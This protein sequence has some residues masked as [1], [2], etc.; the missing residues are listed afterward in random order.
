[1]PDTTQPPSPS[2][3]DAA[4]EPLEI[5][6][7]PTPAPGDTGERLEEQGR[8]ADPFGAGPGYVV[9]RTWGG[10]DQSAPLRRERTSPARPEPPAPRPR[11][12]RSGLWKGAGIALLAAVVGAASA[13]GIFLALDEDSPPVTVV[14]QIL[15]PEE[16][17][18]NAAAVA[19]RVLPSIVTVQ[20]R[21]SDVG[22]FVP[23]G[24][25]S[26]VVLSDDGLLITNNHVVEGSQQVRVI[27]AD[28]RAYDAEVVGTDALSDVAVLR[29]DADG[30]VPIELGASGSMAVGDTAIAI[31]SPLGLTGGPSVTVGVVSAFERRVQTS[32]DEE[33]F[34]MLQTDAPI[35][36]GSSGGALVDDHGRLIGITTA[37]GIS[38]VGAEG[39]G[40]AIPIEMV[41]RIADDLIE[42]GEARHAFLGVEGSTFYTEAPDGATIPGGVAVAS[43]FDDTAAKLSGIEEGDVILS[44]GDDPVTTMEQLV[45]VI[46]LYRVDETVDVVISRGGEETTIP[47]TLLERPEGV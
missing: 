43:V 35:T 14:E 33:L 27:F 30:L 32:I 9:T 15:T 37:I 42:F 23:D 12:G 19:R 24:S 38:D 2:P 16:T 6:I 46:R 13:T 31:G 45:T 44:V 29:I 17:G 26:G 47:V 39:L 36:R 21:S 5:S 3:E 41:T 10:G 1:M 8:G 18:S 22:T 25:G 34:G 28:G 20:V 7:E 11:K 40:F 4:A